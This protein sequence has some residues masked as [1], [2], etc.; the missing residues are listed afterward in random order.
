MKFKILISLLAVIAVAGCTIPS[1]PGITGGGPLI[2]TGNGLEITSFTAQPDT[3]YSSSNVRI[4]MEIE[5]KGETT[6]PADKSIA[7]LTGSNIEFSSSPSSTMVWH[8]T[9]QYQTLKE[10]K[11]QDV[12]RGITGTTDRV[13][14]TLTAPSIPRGQTRADTFIGRVY[15]DYKTTAQ[16]SVWVYTES[17][18]EASRT[19]GRSLERSS[20]TTTKGPVGLSVSVQPDPVILYAGEK[21]FSISI[22]IT[23]LATGTIYKPGNITYNTGS[24]GK[25]LVSDA[26]NKVRLNITMQ[27]DKLSITT[28]ECQ[29]TNEQELVAGRPT[30]IICDFDITEDLSTLTFKSY[31]IS[32]SIDYGYFTERTATVTVQGK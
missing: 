19:A 30:T 1:I 16:G 17:E 8:D 9:S 25:A 28:T 15:C 7:Y 12:V 21:T 22:K 11:S 5:N 18:A 27:S 6:V 4:I 24:T 14:W 29:G 32:V 31:P 3:L 23:N 20:F 13:T 2:G 10:M 26:L